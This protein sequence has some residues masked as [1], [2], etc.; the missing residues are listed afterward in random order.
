MKETLHF[1]HDNTG[2]KFLHYQ[3][4]MQFVSVLFACRKEII[5]FKAQEFLLTSIAYLVSDQVVVY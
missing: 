4:N 1:V 2:K 3:Q 5:T